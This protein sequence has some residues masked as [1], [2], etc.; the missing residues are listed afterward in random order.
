MIFDK[1]YRGERPAIS[2]EGTGMGC[3]IAKAIGRLTEYDCGNEPLDMAR[4]R[5]RYGARKR[6]AVNEA[7][8]LVVDDEPQIRAFAYNAFEPRYVIIDAKT[9]KKELSWPQ[10]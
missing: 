10:G 9:G 7:T 6:A 8:I 1:F 4:F 2:R 5:L 3:Q